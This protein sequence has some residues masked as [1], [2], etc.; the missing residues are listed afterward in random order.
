MVRRKCLHFYFQL[1]DFLKLKNRIS[2]KSRKSV[3]CAI[4]STSCLVNGYY[5]QCIASIELE[6]EEINRIRKYIRCEC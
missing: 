5:C 1:C 3:F 2:Y 4:M 6:I